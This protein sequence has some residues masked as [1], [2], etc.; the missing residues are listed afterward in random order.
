VL[1]HSGIATELLRSLLG[2]D[3]LPSQGFLPR[4]HHGRQ[5]DRRHDRFDRTFQELVP[6]PPLTS[7]AAPYRATSGMS[8]KSVEL[9]RAHLR[10]RLVNLA[11][12]RMAAGSRP[13]GL[14]SAAQAT[15]VLTA[16]PAPCFFQAEEAGVCRFLVV[17]V[18]GIVPAAAAQPRRTPPR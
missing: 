9:S 7:A 12:D 11:D 1:T 17:R 5:P 13:A 16:E 18:L 6:A 10:W 2:A 15:E 14:V 8:G 4:R 3:A